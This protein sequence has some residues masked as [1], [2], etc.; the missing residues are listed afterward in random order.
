[1]AVSQKIRQ[2]MAEGGWIRRVFEE[3][4]TLKARIG[5]RK[6]L[7]PVPWQ[8]RYRAPVRVQKRTAASRRTANGRYAPLHAQPRLHG[9]PP[10]GRRY[11]GRRDRPPFHRK[12]NHHDLRRRSCRQCGAEDHSQ[13]RRRGNHPRPPTSSSI[14]TTSTIT[15]ALPWSSTPRISSASTYPP[16]SRQS[17]PAPAPSSST[18]PTTLPA[19]CIRRKRSRASHNCWTES[20]RNTAPRSSW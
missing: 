16:S 9:D 19:W 14:S 2:F 5:R 15:T 1:M 10:G 7:R 11:P 20:S 17:L 18:R 3:G 4:L 13:P 12:R 8:P 6:R